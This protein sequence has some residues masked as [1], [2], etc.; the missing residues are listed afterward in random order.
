[1]LLIQNFIFGSS[2]WLKLG[3][4]LC[5]GVICTHSMVVYVPLFMFQSK[6]WLSLK[7]AG[8]ID[9]F[10]TSSQRHRSYGAICLGALCTVYIWIL[11]VSNKTPFYYVI[12]FLSCWA[13]YM[14]TEYTLTMNIHHVTWQWTKIKQLVFKIF[15][16][17]FKVK[18]LKKT[19][20]KKKIIYTL[21]SHQNIFWE[22]KFLTHASFVST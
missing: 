21:T 22:K 3:A 7:I 10:S 5:S 4:H 17:L 20:K 19:L 16:I 6:C 18:K 11:H 15:N 14:W 2:V 12:L 8:Q 1:M 13:S 9:R